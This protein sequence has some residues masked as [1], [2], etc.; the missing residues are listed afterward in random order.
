MQFP[1]PISVES[2]AAQFQGKVIGDASLVATGINEIHKV[3]PG[4]ITFSDVP[5]YFERSLQ[6]AATVIL[7]NAEAVCPLGK[8][9]I[10]VENPFLVYDTIV[11]RY[12]PFRAITE[13]VHKS[14]QI[15]ASAI[16]E[17]GVRIGAHVVIG[18]NTYIQSNAYIGE[19]TRIGQRVQI[20]AGSVIG[21]DAFYYRKKLTTAFRNGVQVPG[22]HPRQR[23]YWCRLHNQ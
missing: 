16:I 11:R 10:V 22:H 4:D 5:K 14:A 1:E 8:A 21:T 19:Y 6:S 15:H 12:R 7:L 20:G 18:A 9:I 2:I 13:D 17:P 23:R 3:T